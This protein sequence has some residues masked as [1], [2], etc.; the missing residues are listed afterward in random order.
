MRRNPT[1]EESINEPPPPVIRDGRD[2]TPV[3]RQLTEAFGDEAFRRWLS[4]VLD[5]LRETDRDE[6]VA[7]ATQSYREISAGAIRYLLGLPPALGCAS[8]EELLYGHESS[9]P[10]DSEHSHRALIVQWEG[11][12]TFFY[13]SALD[14]TIGWDREKAWAWAMQLGEIFWGELDEVLSPRIELRKVLEFTQVNSE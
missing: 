8:A 3:Q 1:R 6:A 4:Q 11:W 5:V 12:L 13:V 10:L 7:K 9:L 14:Q 2:I